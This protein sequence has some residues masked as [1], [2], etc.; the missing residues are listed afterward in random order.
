MTNGGSMKYF[1][2]LMSITLATLLLSST[3]F[4]AVSINKGAEPQENNNNRDCSA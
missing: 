3:I 2:Y 1:K 4:G